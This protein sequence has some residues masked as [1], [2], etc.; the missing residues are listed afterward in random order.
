MP[1]KQNLLDELVHGLRRPVAFEP[2]TVEDDGELIK[3]I[4]SDGQHH[5]NQWQLTEDTDAAKL[6]KF[7]TDVLSDWHKND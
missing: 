6:D 1:T 2:V 5:D 7:W 4:E 3:A